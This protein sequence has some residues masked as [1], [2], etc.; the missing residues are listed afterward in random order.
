MILLQ[1]R[2]HVNTVSQTKSNILP[3]EEQSQTK[4]VWLLR[5]TTEDKSREIGCNQPLIAYL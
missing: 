1:P 4:E 2:K 5:T 3:E